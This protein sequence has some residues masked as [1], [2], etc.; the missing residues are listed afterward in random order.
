[1]RLLSLPSLSVVTLM[2]DVAGPV[3]IDVLA[4]SLII[5]VVDGIKFIRRCSLRGEMNTERGL[6]Q[7]KSSTI[8]NSIDNRCSL[9]IQLILVHKVYFFTIHTKT[10]CHSDWG[11]PIGPK[12]S[13]RPEMAR[14]RVFSWQ[15]LQFP[16]FLGI[17]AFFF[18]AKF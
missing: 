4:A 3:P 15:S 17:F 13:E 6:C 14:F 11:A 9:R 16:P 2:L 5:Y 7:N 18:N 8:N 1:M 10:R 12:I